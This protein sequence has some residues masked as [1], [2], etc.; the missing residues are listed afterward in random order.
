MQR[1][2]GT[3]PRPAD[4]V[5]LAQ[6]LRRSDHTIDVD[7]LMIDSP[8]AREMLEAGPSKATE[9][10]MRGSLLGGS[11]GGVAFA[12]LTFFGIPVLATGTLLAGI[13]GA[14]TA[15]VPAGLLGALIGLGIPEDEAEM[16]KIDLEKGGAILVADARDGDEDAVRDRIQASGAE[17]VRAMYP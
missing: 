16:R 9:G 13:A 5:A 1:I 10:F 12:T 14:A 7:V 4:A 2:Y 3:Y 15:A 17:H 8:K 11:L 6:E